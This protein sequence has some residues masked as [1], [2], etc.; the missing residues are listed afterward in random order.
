VIEKRFLKIFAGDLGVRLQENY[1]VRLSF[2]RSFEWCIFYY[3]YTTK[4]FD[5]VDMIG[6][7]LDFCISLEGGTFEQYL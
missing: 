1:I 7:T 4:N 5:P 2:S 6:K 3:E